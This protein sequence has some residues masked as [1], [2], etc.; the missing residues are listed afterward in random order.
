MQMTSIQSSNIKAAGYENNTL[1]VRFGNGTEYDYKGVSPQM[2]DGLM[3]AKSQGKFFNTVI[4]SKFTGTKVEKEQGD[5]DKR[6]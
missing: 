2:F 5:G 6:E 1:R 4:R 3:L